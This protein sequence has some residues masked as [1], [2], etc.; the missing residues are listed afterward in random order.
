MSTTGLRRSRR[1]HIILGAVLAFA[2]VVT[3]GL[4][5]LAEHREQEQLA[6][7]AHARV[8]ADARSA[9]ADEAFVTGRAVAVNRAG[10]QHNL[11]RHRADTAKGV[12]AARAVLEAA[13]GK[14]TDDAH[15]AALE[16]MLRDAAEAVPQALPAQ[17][18]ALQY[19]VDAEVAAVE[20]SHAD[21]TAEQE[22][23]AAERAKAAAE[24]ARQ[25]ELERQRRAQQRTESTSTSGS[26][27]GGSSS[28]TSSASTGGKT[29]QARAVLSRYGCGSAGIR[30]D[31]SRLGG[32]ANGKAD[33]YHNT[34][35]LRSAMPSSR[36]TYVIAHECVHLIQYRVYGGNVD[37]LAADMNRIYGG[38]GFSGLEQNADCVT[39]RW[40]ISTYNYTTSCGGA[41][42]DAAAA[43]AAGHK[44]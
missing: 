11:Q 7:Q 34:I 10:I 9:A 26:G 14:V 32:W 41:R 36:F 44:P 42:G 8:L 18:R 43:I 15:T 21:W 16:A 27:S 13:V 23:L 1:L 31:D 2:L 12:L 4:V 20:K 25:A 6:A 38:S 28:S 30:W 29:D 5:Q 35:L 39:Q 33:W 40:G 3:I 17:L 19:G 24:R 37:A 22:R